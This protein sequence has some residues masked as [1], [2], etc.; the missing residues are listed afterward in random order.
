MRPRRPSAERRQPPTA[1]GP[2]QP[3]RPRSCRLLGGSPRRRERP[4]RGKTPPCPPATLTAFFM[5][6]AMLVG[7]NYSPSAQRRSWGHGKTRE[8]ERKR[9]AAAT[10][11][12]SGLLRS[13]APPVRRAAR[14]RQEHTANLN[15]SPQ[16]LVRPV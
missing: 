10:L 8:D 11:R 14:R 1:G 7:L 5:V 3:A 12:G 2:G 6:A 13:P 16:R 9:P 15:P 4:G